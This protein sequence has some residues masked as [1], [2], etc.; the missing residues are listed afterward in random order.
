MIQI[1]ENGG[2]LPVEKKNVSF[3][4][5]VHCQWFGSFRFTELKKSWKIFEHFE[6]L[7][8]YPILMSFYRDHRWHARYRCHRNYTDTFWAF[9]VQIARL[10]TPIQPSLIDVYRPRRKLLCPINVY[11]IHWEIIW[12]YVIHAHSFFINFSQ[13]FPLDHWDPYVWHR[14]FH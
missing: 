12:E 2:L 13:L 10:V 14:Q 7:A 9:L 4:E 8:M 6:I 5:D 1:K 11:L 3:H